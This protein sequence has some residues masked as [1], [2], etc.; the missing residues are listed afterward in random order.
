MSTDDAVHLEIDDLGIATVTIDRPPV[1]AL[2][3]SDVAKITET[4]Q[5]IADD[6]AVRV[7]ILTGAGQRAF[8]AGADVNELAA[9]TPET[10]ITN[11][12]LIQAC[13]DLVYELP[14]R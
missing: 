9:M 3:F 5:R 10:A 4:F 1:N 8:V 13:V 6:E 11:T 12:D 2:R 7:V 14:N